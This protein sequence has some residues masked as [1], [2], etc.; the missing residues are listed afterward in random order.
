MDKK[1]LRFNGHEVVHEQTGVMLQYKSRENVFAKAHSS[2]V[3]PA[4]TT[5]CPPRRVEGRVFKNSL[6]FDI[7][8]VRTAVQSYNQRGPLDHTFF[9]AL[10]KT[11]SW[12]YQR[13]FLR[14]RP[15]S[16]ALFEISTNLSTAF[17]ISVIFRDFCTILEIDATFAELQGR[18][19]I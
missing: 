11:G 5:F 14:V 16:S 6:T 7:L 10:S 9:L 17:Q 13:R 18:Q 1:T 3:E 12:L 19:Q 15:H 2:A 8:G 4:G